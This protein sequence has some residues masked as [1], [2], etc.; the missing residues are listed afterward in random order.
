VTA[1][2]RINVFLLNYPQSRLLTSLD[3]LSLT[4]LLFDTKNVRFLC[5]ASGEDTMFFKNAV[6]TTHRNE[7]KSGA[8][9]LADH[10]RDYNYTK[11][12]TA[13]DEVSGAHAC[14]P[15]M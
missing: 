7:R 6:N 2:D 1:Y 3:N 4:Q 12:V 8:L 5:L 11:N 10:I 13:I 15:R 14:T 9:W